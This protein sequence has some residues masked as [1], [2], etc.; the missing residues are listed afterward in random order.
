MSTFWEK[1]QVSITG[2]EGFLGGHLIKQLKRKNPKNISIVKHSDYDLVNNDDVKR[3]YDD[4]KP[5]IVFH[6]AATVGGIEINKK[7]P[8]R[9]F[10]ENAI[11]NLQVMHNAHLSKIDKIICIGTVSV[12][13]KNTELPFKEKNIWEGYPQDENA[14]Y[15]IAKRIMHTHSL[16]YRKQYDLNSI[17]VVLTNLYGPNDNFNKDSSHVV[18]ALI[19]RFYEA[20]KN[21]VKEVLVWGDGNATRDFSYIEDIAEGIILSAENYNESLPINLAS[22]R[23]TSIKELA[24]II[25]K[26]MNYEGNLRWDTEM[27]V[28]PNRRN[29]S[30]DLAREKIKFNPKI[31]LEDGIEKTIDFFMSLKK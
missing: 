13:P 20:K 5:D 21:N 2:G 10:Y 24:E 29:V 17:M 14:P 31:S 3:M 4:Q 28:G 6:L 16:G 1:K 19:R 9:F 18:A 8:G 27:P 11:M 22:G 7:N 15:G 26:K 25:K 12:Y 30:I 23:E